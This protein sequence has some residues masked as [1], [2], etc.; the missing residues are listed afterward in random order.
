MSTTRTTRLGL[1]IPGVADR[2]YNL[3]IDPNWGAIDGMAALGSLCVVANETPSVSLSVKVSAGTFRTSIGADVTYAGI[4]GLAVTA[5]TTTKVWLDE[6]G[7]IHT[8]ASYPT[9]PI[10]KLASVT[11]DTSTVTAIVD[12]RRYLA[13]TGGQPRRPV[14]TVTAS[15]DTPSA[16]DGLILADAT[17]VGI[18]VTLPTLTASDAG[19]EIAVV[20]TDASVN[21]VTVTTVPGAT[22]TLSAQFD[23]INAIWSG[24]AW[25]AL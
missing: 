20:K 9:G 8:G 1:G 12:D 6:A 24:T 25:L 14:R 22:T 18:A 3:V 10:L 7:T 19:L 17:F 11:A 15:T 16:T 2:N 23:K 5:S 4:T 21:S 13:T